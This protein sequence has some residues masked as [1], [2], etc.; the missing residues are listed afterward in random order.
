MK[1][2]IRALKAL[3]DETKLRMLNLLAGQECCVCEVMQALDISQSRASRNLGALHNAGFLKL[4]KDGLWSIYSLDK[5]G[6]PAYSLDLAGVV[7]KALSKNDVAALDKKRLEKALR[8][9]PRRLSS[10]TRL[11]EE[12]AEA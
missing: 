7:I 11:L 1:E 4:R 2:L 10:A 9:S 8:T 6:I 3:S 12:T 5:E